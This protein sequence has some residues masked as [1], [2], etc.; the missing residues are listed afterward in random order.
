MEGGEGGEGG[1]GIGLGVGGEVTGASVGSFV[2]RLSVRL[3]V[4]G[5][6]VLW[7]APDGAGCSRVKNL[8]Q[9]RE[10]MTAV[11]VIYY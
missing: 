8:N 5:L 4:H 11:A 9:R 3:S 10:P 6:S 7:T 1:F 2:V